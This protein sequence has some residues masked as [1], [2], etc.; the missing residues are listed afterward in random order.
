MKQ[1][2]LLALIAIPF[3]ALL[4][5]AGCDTAVVTDSQEQSPQDMT[6]DVTR[7]PL[8]TDGE[9]DGNDHPAVVLLVM[10]VGG[11]PT[12]RCS[13]TLLSR[14]VVLTA[15]HCTNNFPGAPFTGLR[16]FTESDVDGG[17]GVTN[18]FP[19]CNAGS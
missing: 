2:P 12:F 9:L 14:R 18:T 8:I 11:V 16:V 15:G 3:S 7:D 19:F 17:I 5:A 4:F 1:S 10:D 6:A 13:A